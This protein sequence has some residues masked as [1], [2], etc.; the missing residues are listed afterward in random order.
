MRVALAFRAAAAAQGDE[1]AVREHA[2]AARQL[3]AMTR[4]D[5]ENLAIA[6]H[7]HGLDA[8]ADAI[9]ALARPSVR[10]V[11]TK[12]DDAT[13]PVGATKIGGAPDLPAY[14]KW[15]MREGRR[16]A[17]IDATDPA[18]EAEARESPAAAV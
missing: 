9:R 7:E 14:F 10:L 5:E 3:A 2:A 13:I 6:I 11:A 18:L 4:S 15:P 8:H 17:F 16:L 1:D 12:A